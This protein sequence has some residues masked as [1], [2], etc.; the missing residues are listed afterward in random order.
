M[1]KNFYR[2]DPIDH[3]VYK[4]LVS[5][6]I[7]KNISE[8]QNTENNNNLTERNQYKNNEFVF[9]QSEKKNVLIVGNNI[10]TNSVF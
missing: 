5:S 8:N 2:P 9:M 3:S 7:Q 1:Q 6:R 4:R 10:Q